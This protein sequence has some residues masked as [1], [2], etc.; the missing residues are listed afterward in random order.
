MTASIMRGMAKLSILC[1][2]KESLK[3]MRILMKEN[4][5]SVLLVTTRI[6]LRGDGEEVV[7]KNAEF[8][9]SDNLKL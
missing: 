7:E 4:N 8:E 2:E 9:N 1:S 6:L 3:I 5:L